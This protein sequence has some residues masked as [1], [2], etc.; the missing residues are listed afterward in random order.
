MASNYGRDVNRSTRNEAGLN[1]TV[2]VAVALASFLGGVLA[3]PA[4]TSM[5]AE[6]SSTEQREAEAPTNQ[7]AVTPKKE[8]PAQTEA[9]EEVAPNPEPEPRHSWVVEPTARQV[10]WPVP[11]S[12]GDTI[13]VVATGSAVVKNQ[14]DKGIRAL[15]AIDYHLQPG[16]NVRANSGNRAGTV[17]QRAHDLNAAIRDE[18]VRAIWCARG[19]SDSI[20]LLGPVDWNSYERDNAKAFI[21]YSDVTVLQLALYRRRGIIS[22]SGPMVAEDHGF[23]GPHR[24]SPKTKRDLFRWLKRPM[25]KREIA[26]LYG[27]PIKT[28]RSGEAEGWLLGGNLSRVCMMLDQDS[29]CPDFTGAVLVLED[30]NENEASFRRMIGKLRD[31]GV[32][33]KINGVVLGDTDICR[34]EVA[35]AAIERACDDRPVPIAY[36]MDYGH[37]DAPRVTLP[38]GAWCKLDAGERVARIIVHPDRPREAVVA[39]S[40][41]S[42]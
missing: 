11:L 13:A 1:S 22:F 5:W 18:E 10:Y 21:G 33:D 35:L 17:A 40:G 27:S 4:L 29:Y 36:N 39:S 19:G 3:Q 38:I 6:L 16:D 37:L 15:E 32:F 26:N 2:L 12:E 31:R 34:P 20:D 30:I 14:L 9:P 25:Q 23:G 7:L 42:R 8:P 41:Q 28:H 24:F